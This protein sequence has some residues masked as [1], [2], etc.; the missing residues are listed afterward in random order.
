M[1]ISTGATS[2][3]W[4]RACLRLDLVLSSRDVDTGTE[5]L[6]LQLEFLSCHTATDGLESGVAILKHSLRRRNT[7]TMPT[8]MFST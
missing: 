3:E 7:M 8:V 6:S 2:D 1:T 5:E 4:T